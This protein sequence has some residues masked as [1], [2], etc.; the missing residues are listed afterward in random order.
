MESIFDKNN[1]N[2]NL[3]KGL[4]SM[5][6]KNP[7]APD[8]VEWK[9]PWVYV[10]H[11][12]WNCVMADRDVLADL[13]F[14]ALVY[15]L[16]ITNLRTD[17]CGD[18]L[19]AYLNVKVV[20]S[21]LLSGSFS[22]TVEHE[23]KRY[24]KVLTAVNDAYEPDEYYYD[25]LKVV[26]PHKVLADSNLLATIKQAFRNEAD[27]AYACYGEYRGY[28]TIRDLGLEPTADNVD[29]I[30]KAVSRVVY[31]LSQ[32]FELQRRIC[33]YYVDTGDCYGYSHRGLNGFGEYTSVDYHCD[34][35]L[36]HLEDV[37]FDYVK[38]LQFCLADEHKHDLD[39]IYNWV[40]DDL[41]IRENVIDAESARNNRAYADAW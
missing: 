13:V 20:A 4:K 22:E 6:F 14:D 28:E 41:K 27:D 29:R 24:P 38:L 31:N 40:E 21:D 1:F 35:R 25:H 36:W 33:Q 12:L 3:K 32:A 23:V 15:G 8:G 7:F 39:E 2:E 18:N 26:V 17:S 37:L 11:S 30:Y 16:D 19:K 5:S 34:S 9:L 10:G